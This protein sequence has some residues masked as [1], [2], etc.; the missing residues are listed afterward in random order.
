MGNKPGKRGRG[1]TDTESAEDMRFGEAMER[2]M[3]RF[4]KQIETP[5]D[6]DEEWKDRERYDGNNNLNG[7]GDERYK[8]H[9]DA[10]FFNR[11]Y[12]PYLGSGIAPV[13]SAADVRSDVNSEFSADIELAKRRSDAGID[14]ID[15]AEYSSDQ[16]GSNEREDK[17][18]R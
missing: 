12:M 18:K 10:A 8:V 14:V 3:E 5:R 7:A 2:D 4:S 11:M 16:N 13:R 17:R 9:T 1:K 6:V 15:G